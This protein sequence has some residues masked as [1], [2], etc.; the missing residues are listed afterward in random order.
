MTGGEVRDSVMSR[1]T[2]HLNRDIW[3][4]MVKVKAGND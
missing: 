2:K 1:G 3:N 4:L